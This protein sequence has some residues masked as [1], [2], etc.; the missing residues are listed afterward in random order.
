MTREI[1]IGLLVLVV[2]A[3]SL[4]LYNYIK[5]KNILTMD[6]SY[7]IEYS[8]IDRL[9]VSDPVL[10]RGF[11]IG[12]VIDIGLKEG[13]FQTIVVQ[14]TLNE[15][16]KLPKTTEANIVTTSLT[17]E[18]AIE[19]N[20][21][22][23]CSGDNC[24]PSGSTIKGRTVGFVESVVGTDD[25]ERSIKDLSGGVGGLLDS[26]SIQLSNKDNPNA[27]GQVFM[28]IDQTT[29]NLNRAT[30]T[31]EGMLNANQQYF[32]QVM[33]NMAQVTKAINNQSTSIE[34]LLEN[35]AQ[36]TEK[37]NELELDSTLNQTKATMLAGEK[38]LSTLQTTL[39]STSHSLHQLTD[40]LR[41]LNNGEGTAGKLIKD[42]ELYNHL[43]K[44]SE[45]LETLLQDLQERPGRY[46]NLSVIGGRRE[47]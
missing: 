5:G 41:S 4:W 9:E 43:N 22:A 23:P 2:F 38:S 25:L 29:A 17:G 31:L 36:F 33:S 45:N 47:K 8:N 1:K 11:E 7:F 12:T 40:V 16:M 15:G 32:N 30:A 13:D 37:L 19:M 26:L 10:V 6:N 42:E 28:A 3:G 39:D 46:I 21:P 27:I 24:L 20:F 18:K 44:A 34:V 14:V 35:T